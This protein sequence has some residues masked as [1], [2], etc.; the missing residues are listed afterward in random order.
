M[1]PIVFCALSTVNKGLVQ[2]LKDLE[3]RVLMETIIE[4]GQN[5]GKS[6]GDLKKLA[7]TQTAVRNHRLTL[8][9]KT[10]NR[11][12]DNIEVSFRDSNIAPRPD[13]G[14]FELKRYCVDLVSNKSVLLLGLHG[15]YF[16]VLYFTTLFTSKLLLYRRI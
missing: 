14:S 11:V 1:I 2:R 8:V 16:V 3:I 10:R 13:A 15:Y 5:T 4:V 6:H 7:V 12:N 9:R